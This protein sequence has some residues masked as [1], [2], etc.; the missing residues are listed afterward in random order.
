MKRFMLPLGA[1]LML[2]TAALSITGCA[3]QCGATPERL[4]SLRRGMSYEETAQIMGCP[5]TNVTEQRPDSG[6]FATVEWNGPEQYIS[7]RTQVDFLDGKLLS[8]TTGV[9][10]GW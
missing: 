7:K 10:G 5:G 2:S 8:Y 3:F 4:A 6:E 9:R 1:V